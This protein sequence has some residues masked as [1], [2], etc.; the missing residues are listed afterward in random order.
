MLVAAEDLRNKVRLLAIALA[1]HPRVGQASPM[2][3]LK[4]D[5]LA[6]IALL[7]IS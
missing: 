6:K 5:L 1:S 2:G 3:M 7:T 4:D